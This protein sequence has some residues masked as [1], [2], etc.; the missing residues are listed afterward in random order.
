MGVLVDNQ[1]NTGQQCAQL[2][3]KGNDILA[4]I[5]NSVINRTKAVIVLLYSALV[6]SRLE[7]CVQFW[8]THYKKYIKG[9]GEKLLLAGSDQGETQ[10][11]SLPADIA[12]PVADLT[13]ISAS[14]KSR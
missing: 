8:A 14:P 9:N 13:V 4:C 3:K 7:C 2:V 12:T 1:L 6:R 5:K 11:H 10:Q